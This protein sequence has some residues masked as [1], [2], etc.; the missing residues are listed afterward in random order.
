MSDDDYARIIIYCI[1][2]VYVDTMATELG[3]ARYYIE[4]GLYEAKERRRM[5]G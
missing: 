3:C 5:S 1:T 2:K 4:L